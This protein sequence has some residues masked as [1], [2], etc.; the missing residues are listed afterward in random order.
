MISR[1][2]IFNRILGLQSSL[3]SCC[4]NRLPIQLNYAFPIFSRQVLQKRPLDRT[5]VRF[6]FLIS[7]ISLNNLLNHHQKCFTKLLPI[8]HSGS[9]LNYF[10]LHVHKTVGREL[11][12]HEFGIVPCAFTPR[13][14]EGFGIRERG[15]AGQ[16]GE[17]GSHV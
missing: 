5:L 2:Q 14:H 3:P 1:R 15:R 8:F 9:M 7:P 13:I 4:Q 12:P 17:C 16:R 6:T 11:L 10:H